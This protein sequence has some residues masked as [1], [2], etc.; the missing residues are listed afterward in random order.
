MLRLKDLPPVHNLKTL[1]PKQS[2][3]HAVGKGKN[4][5]PAE[6]HP[7]GVDHFKP[8][9]LTSNRLQPA[10]HHTF[11]NL[12]GNLS[13]IAISDLKAQDL[14][15]AHARQAVADEMI[16]Y[17]RTWPK[18]KAVVGVAPA[19]DKTY[20]IVASRPHAIEQPALEGIYEINQR[21]GS[22]EFIKQHARAYPSKR[23]E[24]TY[25]DPQAKTRQITLP[26]HLN[27]KDIERA[28]KEGRSLNNYE[29]LK[30]LIQ[31]L[32]Q[33]GRVALLIGGP[34]AAGKSTLIKKIQEYAGNRHVT[35]I[36]GDMYFKDID[37]PQGYPLTDKGTPYW[38]HEDFMDLNRLNSDL[39]QLITT[40]EADT[41]VYNFQDVRPGGWRVP[42]KYTGF[43]EDKPRHV[44]CG[45]NDILVV[46]SIHATNPKVIDYFNHLGLPYVSI[47]LDSLKAD[48]RLLR[49][50]V[51]DYNQRGGRSVEESLEIW[52][53]TTWRGEKEFVRPGILRLDPSQDLFMVFKFPTDLGLNRKEIEK[54][55]QL[56]EYY[57][58][59]PSYEAFA[60]PE[61]DLP[62][63]AAKEKE[64]L[65]GLL[66]SDADEKIKAKAARELEK[67]LNAPANQTQPAKF[68]LATNSSF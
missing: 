34:S 9:S 42:T 57:G 66:Q 29:M 61:E 22:S 6:Q 21:L 7:H 56:M 40:G 8:S 2:H 27:S 39:N 65:Q 15:T 68:L 18:T 44:T 50:I 55:T 35:V 13:H 3:H 20:V 12:K 51:R 45:P 47:Y 31:N 52:D 43:R 63:L 4:P 48:D 60:V 28:L 49:R 30:E 24:I 1:L 32:P 41:P 46:D 17:L 10:S 25:F 33:H 53:Q 58:L 14:K 38:D 26:G 5:A 64:R 16:Q 54:R 36:Q 19:A 23:Y 67:L 59:S 37:D 11:K 62:H